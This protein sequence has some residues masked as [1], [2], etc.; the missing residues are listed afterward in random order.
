MKTLTRA[1]FA[2]FCVIGVLGLFLWVGDVFTPGYFVAMRLHLWLGIALAVAV[3]P[4][5]SA[6]IRRS[7]SSPLWSLLVPGIVLA[8]VGWLLP[9]RPEVPAFGPIGWAAWAT[10]AQLALAA[11]LMP[12]FPVVATKPKPTSIT[13]ILL[14]VALLWCVWTG[15]LGWQLRG[16]ERWGAMLAHSAL[17]ISLAIWLTP[18][19]RKVRKLP[20]WALVPGTALALSALLWVWETTYPHDLI[21]GD[22][23][24]PLEFGDY[25]PIDTGVQPWVVKQASMPVTGEQRADTNRP[26]IDEEAFANSASCGEAGCHEVV[27]KQWE[28][29][30]HRFA[31]DNDFYAKVIELLVAERGPEDAVFCA[32]CHDPVRA[33]AGTAAQAYADGKVPPGDGVSCVACHGISH[34]DPALKNAAFTVSQAPQYPGDTPEERRANLKLDPRLHRQTMAA[35]FRNADPQDHCVACHRVEVTPDVGAATTAELQSAMPGGERNQ[36]LGCTDCHMP[37]LTF[38]RSFEQAMYDHHLSGANLDL[39]DYANHPERDDEAIAATRANTARFLGG[40]LDLKGLE[41]TDYT[42]PGETQDV[43]TKG[44]ALAMTA[45]TQR[46]GSD[47]VVRVRTTNHRA[48]HPFPIAPFDLREVWLH[49]QVTQGDAVLAEVGA[50][51]EDLRVDGWAPRL[52]GEEIGRDGLPLQHHRIWDLAAVRNKRQ[53][54]A[55][56]NIDD[57]VRLSLPEGATGAV[58]VRASWRVRR[59]NQDFADWVYGGGKTF[60]AH[61]LADVEVEVP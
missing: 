48:G 41:A 44:R 13:G 33:L 32:T 15:V 58:S 12:L 50:I 10:G 55:M 2:V 18:H 42:I 14:T 4:V 35:N 49:V 28:G 22:F 1:G 59:V 51:G 57:E 31:A 23:R 7:G 17:G 27:T 45:T 9:G 5:L 60:P 53:I 11:A 8:I 30:A 36:E 21:L 29:S 46:D 3:S 19:F 40:T 34:V 52:G 54:P 26:T 56:G 25:I 61:E 16:D 39:A 20:A 47:L 24:S 43:L 6:H 37:T 38:K